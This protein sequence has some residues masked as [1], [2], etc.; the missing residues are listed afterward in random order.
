MSPKEEKQACLSERN[1]P[2]CRGGLSRRPPEQDGKT[3]RD[4]EQFDRYP[5]S[6]FGTRIASKAAFPGQT[7]M[8]TFRTGKERRSDGR[9]GNI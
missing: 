3:L 6:R 1:P 2:P 9:S 4:A 7:R 5:S 8:G